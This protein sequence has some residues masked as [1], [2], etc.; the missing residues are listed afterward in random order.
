[1]QLMTAQNTVSL[2]Y[3]NTDGINPRLFLLLLLLLLLF[4]LLLL[5]LLLLPPPLLVLLRRRVKGHGAIVGVR[6]YLH[7]TWKIKKSLKN[8]RRQR[9]VYY[10]YIYILGQWTWSICIFVLPRSKAKQSKEKHFILQTNAYF[11]GGRGFFLPLGYISSIFFYFYN[12]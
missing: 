6:D 7:L 9:R 11:E 12:T 10:I 4:L 5:L 3:N 1:M 2:Y 8:W